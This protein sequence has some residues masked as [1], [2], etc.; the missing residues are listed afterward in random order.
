MRSF[1]SARTGR[2]TPT[3]TRHGEERR[4]SEKS[5]DKVGS[6]PFA[7]KQH[8]CVFLFGRSS[9]HLSS[10]TKPTF[11]IFFV[12][13]SSWAS[14]TKKTKR[15][16]KNRCKTNKKPFGSRLFRARS[17]SAA[18]RN[19]LK[20]KCSLFLIL[21]FRRSVCVLDFPDYFFCLFVCFQSPPFPLSPYL[22]Q[23][24]S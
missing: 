11:A 12:F 13:F 18:L 14:A 5:E 21:C 9:S 24:N 20:K 15:R 2:K 6:L 3:N 4:K 1:P 16:K 17:P 22:F 23:Q 10:R 7:V 8:L 19:Q